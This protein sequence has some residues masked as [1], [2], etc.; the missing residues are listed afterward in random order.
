MGYLFVYFIP[1]RRALY[2]KVPSDLSLC[3]AATDEFKVK[4]QGVIGKCKDGALKFKAVM[5]AHFYFPVQNVL[6]SA[7]KLTKMG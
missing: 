1:P 3:D 6:F 2:F 5:L 4:L 7:K